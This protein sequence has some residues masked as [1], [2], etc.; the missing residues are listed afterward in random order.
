MLKLESVSKVYRN[1]FL[2]LDQIDLGIDAGE[3]V[4]ILGSSG[5]GK[6]TLLRLA[7]GLSCPSSGRVSLHD[8]PVKKPQE[9]VGFIFQEPRLMPWL[10]VEANVAFGLRGPSPQRQAAVQRALVRVG[11]SGYAHYYPKQLSGGMAQ[12][13]AIARALARPVVREPPRTPRSR[14][15]PAH[16]IAGGAGA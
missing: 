10:S 1:G 12:R 4:A 7:A 8:Q 5:C 11:L 9:S 2:A 15:R 14:R 3:R 6:S 16:R 13:A